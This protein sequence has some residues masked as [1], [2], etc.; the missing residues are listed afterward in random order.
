MGSRRTVEPCG[1]CGRL[2]R[3]Y[4]EASAGDVALCHPD[5]RQDCYSLVTVYGCALPDGRV[6]T[7]AGWTT[8]KPE[9]AADGG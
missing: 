3:R 6:W 2:P 8:Q 4:Q 7:Y 9:T 5:Q 1:L